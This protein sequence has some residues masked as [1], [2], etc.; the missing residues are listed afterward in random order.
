MHVRP[1]D[2]YVGLVRH[3]GHVCWASWCMLDILVYV[4]HV[5]THFVTLCVLWTC[6]DGFDVWIHV[7]NETDAEMWFICYIVDIYVV[8]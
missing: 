3:F 7:E 1:L 2:M 5:C 6:I 4:G 8:F